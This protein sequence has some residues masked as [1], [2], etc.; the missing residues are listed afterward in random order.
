M[1]LSIRKE[2]SSLAFGIVGGFGGSSA[3]FVVAAL[4]AA[5]ATSREVVVLRVLSAGIYVLARASF[6]LNATWVPDSGMRST[7][8]RCVCLKYLKSGG[9]W[10]F[11]AGIKKPSALRK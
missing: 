5:S 2:T 10:S 8:H 4:N 3:G 1:S 6:S 7:R 11:L 9:G